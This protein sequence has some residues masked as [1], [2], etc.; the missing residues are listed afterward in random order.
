MNYEKMT[1]TLEVNRQ[2]FGEMHATYM[3]LQRKT[4]FL[5]KEQVNAPTKMFQ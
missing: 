5:K 2:L 3:F 4:L 1:Y